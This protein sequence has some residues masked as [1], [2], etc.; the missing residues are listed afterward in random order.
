MRD[1]EGVRRSATNVGLVATAAIFGLNEVA[2]LTIRSPIFKLKT[3]N[4][5]F[6]ALVPSLIAKFGYSQSIHDRVDNLWRIHRNREDKGMGG[7][8]RSSRVNA[9]DQHYQDANY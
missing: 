5:I 7:T 3:Q 6:F 1:I 8:Y 9:E 4:V 2:R